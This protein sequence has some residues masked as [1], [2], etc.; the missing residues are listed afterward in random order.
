VSRPGSTRL[1]LRVDLH[2]PLIAVLLLG[3]LLGGCASQPSELAPASGRKIATLA[4]AEVGRLYRYGDD[5]ERGFD[6]SGLA[7]SVH[8]RSGLG[9]PRTAAAQFAQGRHVSRRSLRAGDLV[10]FHFAGRSIDHVGVYVGS[11][12]FVH[13]PRAGAVVRR[14]RLDAPWFAKRYAGAARY[15]RD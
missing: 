2:L 5:G 6:C 14:V 4:T 9:I 11:G 7:Q 8:A 13:A 15:A 3:L 10:F 1:P 12:E